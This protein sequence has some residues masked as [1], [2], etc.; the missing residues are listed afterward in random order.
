MPK[1]P[2]EADLESYQDELRRRLER[3]AA[4]LES[5]EADARGAPDIPEG[6]YAFEGGVTRARNED[7]AF[8]EVEDAEHREVVEALERIQAG[9]YGRCENCEQWIAKERLHALP[10]ARYCLKCQAE[11]IG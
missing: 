10:E 4:D 3:V 11:L 2:T 1:P 9:T 5:L 6:E 7:A 8:L